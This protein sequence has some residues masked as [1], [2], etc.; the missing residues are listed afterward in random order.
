[1]RQVKK[2]TRFGNKY[3]LQNLYLF[4]PL[5]ILFAVA[6]YRFPKADVVFWVC[7]ILFC[8]GVIGGLFWDRYRL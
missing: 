4:V 8:V 6:Y 5:A 1:M 3:M 7:L 2:Y